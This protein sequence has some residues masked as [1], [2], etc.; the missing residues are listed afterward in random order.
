MQ[1]NVIPV[2]KTW[3]KEAAIRLEPFILEKTGHSLP[4]PW[5]ISRTVPSKAHDGICFPPEY[6]LTGGTTHIFI[7]SRLGQGSEVH[8]IG[9]IA[10]EMLHAMLPSGTGHGK[11]FR[12]AMAQIG[13]GGK[14]TSTE[15]LPGSELE[16]LCKEI[17]EELGP[18]PHLK[19]A[20]PETEAK[21]RKKIRAVFPPIDGDGPSLEVPI[22]EKNATA[23]MEMGY[24]I[25]IIGL[26]DEDDA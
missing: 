20:P 11:P 4:N 19:M 3:L 14:P 2:C 21:T 16:I 24:E 6:C 22:S 7:C 15:L 13:L 17:A 5:D 10:H 1:E 9:V 8:I 12:K 25:E 26:D 18:Y 23:L